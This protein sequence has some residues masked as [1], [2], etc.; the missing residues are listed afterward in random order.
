MSFNSREYEWADITVIAGGVDLLT[1]RAV[2]Y[3]KKVEQEP[4]YAKGREPFA[5]QKGNAS[6]EGELEV[7]KS[8]F[9]ALEDAAGGDITTARFDL[10][11]AYGNPANGDVIRTNRIL[12]ISIGENEEAAKQGDKFMPV[13][14]PFLATGIQ[15][16]V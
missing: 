14:L 4:V 8:G 9:D 12:N 5:I 13:T 3:K 10:L 15:K 11:V 7:L 1:I 6:Y 16:N 2:K